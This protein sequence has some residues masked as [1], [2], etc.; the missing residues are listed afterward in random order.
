MCQTGVERRAQR[1]LAITSA[2]A[3]R[4]LFYV[5]GEVLEKVESF[6]YL[7]RILGQDDNDIRAVWSQIKLA[8]GIW[9][10]VGQ[11][12]QSDN[13]PPKVGAKFYKAIVQSVLLYGS[14]TWNLTKTALARL[15][16]FPYQSCLP[17][18]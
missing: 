14:K 13:T 18:G 4:Q 7:G 6:R 2:L 16:G 8:R 5:K 11:V 12:L 17:N 9:A 1:D 3:L 15:E 10:R